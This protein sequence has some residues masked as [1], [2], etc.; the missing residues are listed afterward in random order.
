MPI[1]KMD[2]KK[3]GLQR[4]RVRINYTD[5]TGKNRQLERVAYGREA[6]KDLERRLNAELKTGNLTGKRMTLR[7]PYDEY[8]QVKTHEVRGSSL[9]K[10]CL[11]LGYYVLPFIGDIY[12]DKINAPV[13]QKWKLE[14]E[15]AKSEKTGRALCLS[16][17]KNI[18][19]ELRAMLNY[20]V[21]MEYI[22]KNPLLAVGNF[23]DVY[24]ETEK[25]V[26]YYTP[27]EFERF[28]SCAY[29][30]AITNED[31]A[32]NYI[33]W[34]FYVFFS[35]A[36]FTG[37]RKGEIHALK[38][39]DIDGDILHVRR[40]I[41]QK[42]KGGDLETPPKNKC[43]VRDLQIPLPLKEVLEHHYMRY[44]TLDGFT[45][46]WRICGGVKSLRDT[47]IQRRN[48]FYAKKAGLKVIRIH[49]YRHPYVKLKLKFLLT[50]HYRC[51][52]AKV[53]DFP[54][55]FKPVVGVNIHFVYEH[56][57]EC[58]CQGVFLFHCFCCLQSF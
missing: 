19:G 11:R 32:Q 14:V 29:E 18:Y 47:T 43:S 25:R 28:I 17:K 50:Q 39:T 7:Q 12:L 38:W 35:I 41:R 3:D 22:P 40:S 33:D 49:D 9:E 53:L 45:D 34:D 51:I 21:K 46:N 6:A 31:T 20:A 26:D 37:L 8:E 56:I 42:A 54:L 1:Y 4:Y 36:Y 23:K 13:L 44:S 52:S 16:T 15:A 30:Q 10:I 5:N 24:F 55:N 27:E 57:C 2:G 58:L 48:E